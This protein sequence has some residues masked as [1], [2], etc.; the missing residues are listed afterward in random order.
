MENGKTLLSVT[1]HP[2]RK[3]GKFEMTA[4]TLAKRLIGTNKQDPVSPDSEAIAFYALNQIIG[5]MAGK[6]TA[7]EKLPAWGERAVD[8]YCKELIS[9]HR[10]LFIY[11]FLVASREWRHLKNLDLTSSK[12][13]TSHLYPAGMK[14]LHPH[15]KDSHDEATLNSWLKMVPE[16]HIEKYCAALTHSFNTGSWGGGYGGKPWGMISQTLQRYVGGEI[17]AE[18]FIDTAYT[19]AHNNG[20]MFNKGMLYEMYTGAFKKV[21]DIQ[22][23]GQ[24]CEGLIEG[25]CPCNTKTVID[26]KAIIADAKSTLGIGEYVDWYKVEDLGGAL[27]QSGTYAAKKAKQDQKYGTK[28]KPSLINGKPVT[29]TGKFEWYPH[30]QVDIYTRIAA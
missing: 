11:T 30:Q 22:R 8:L 3:T 18:V 13:T 14:A 19:L 26:I 2:L 27:V 5:L 17:S 10:R 23:S 25:E 29:I 28:P 15:I 6:F 24:V 21:L 4:A 16:V 9:Q 12:V 1:S 20:P 7:N